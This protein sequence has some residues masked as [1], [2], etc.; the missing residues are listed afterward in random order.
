[1]S[2][3]SYQAA[4]PRAGMLTKGSTASQADVRHNCIL[5]STMLKPSMRIIFM[6]TPEFA[7]PSLNALLQSGDQVVGVVSQP[8]R[9]KGRGHQLVAP[10]VKLVAEQAGIPVLQPLKIRRL[11]FCKPC[12]PGSRI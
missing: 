12:P 4:P 1:M 8:D 7:V 9:P 6:G 2:P 10:P 3:T 11:N 5:G